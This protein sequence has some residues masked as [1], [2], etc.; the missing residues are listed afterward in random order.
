MATILDAPSA[1]GNYML[2]GWVRASNL[3]FLDLPLRALQVLTNRP[4]P[5]TGCRIPL[6]RSPEAQDPVV[7]LCVNC[8]ENKN[9]M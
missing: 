1:L 5:N 3:F 4:C 7:H 6:L 9:G 2:K 8:D